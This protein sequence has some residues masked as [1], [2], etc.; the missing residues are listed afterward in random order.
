MTRAAVAINGSIL[1]IS[2]VLDFE[3]VLDI[4]AQGQ[5]WLANTAPPQ[6][7]IDLAAVSYCSSVG[8]ALVLGWMRV[9][10]KLAKTLTLKNIPADMLALAS[11][12]GLDTVLT[13][14]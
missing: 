8:V 14:H 9:A 5:Q 2:G 4:D 11:V 13:G 7:E 6:C 3:S 10:Q 1:S 12:S